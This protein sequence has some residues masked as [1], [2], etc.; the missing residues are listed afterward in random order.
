MI[1]QDRVDVILETWKRHRP[2]ADLGGRQIIW[3]I[4][5][6]AKYIDRW[7][8]DMAADYPGMST[9]G[10]RALQSIRAGGPPYRTTPGA[11]ADGLMLTS[12]TMTTLLDR[13]AE[14][15]ML[16]RLP[17]PSDRR[18]I[19]IELTEQGVNTATEISERYRKLEAEM[20]APLP[21]E[22]RRR[23][24]GL[25]R[26]LL[27]GFERHDPAFAAHFPKDRIPGSSKELGT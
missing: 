14:H 21:E 4:Q 12:G 9:S 27:L 5:M 13:L 10:A 15:G 3:R 25:L 26:T 18:A 6:L 24:I 17:D 19:I 2:E 11:L 20:L 22:D 7:L 1:D 16:E 23:L 8:A